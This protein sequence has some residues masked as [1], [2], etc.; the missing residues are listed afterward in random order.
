MHNR[1][2]ITIALATALAY[3]AVATVIALNQRNTIQEL[4]KNYTYFKGD[5]PYI[6]KAIQLWSERSKES[7]QIILDTRFP[8]TMVINRDVC[9]ELRLFMGSI[10]GNPVYCFDETSRRLTKKMD[11]VD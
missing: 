9:V 4:E 3:S 6:D 2:V 7:K 1:S 8:V 11:V 5:Q 10:G